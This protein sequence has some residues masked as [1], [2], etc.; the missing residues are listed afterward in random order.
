M[1]VELKKRHVVYM[2]I[3]T[4]VVVVA[5]TVSASHNG[6]EPLFTDLDQFVLFAEQ[7]V[8]LEEDV[9]I[10]S[11]DTGSN[12]EINIKK[13][14]I[15]SGN[16]FANTVDLEKRSVINGNASF[17][18]LKIKKDAEILGEQIT[19]VSLPIAILPTIPS[20]T[21]G[22]QNFTFTGDGNTLPQG[23]FNNVTLKKDATLTLSGGMYNVS[24]LILNN[25]STLIF[26]TTTTINIIKE[27]IGHDDVSILPDANIIFDDITINYDGR[28]NNNNTKEVGIKPVIFGKNS[29]LNFKLLAP[30][31]KVLLGQQTTLRGQ[32]VAKEIRVGKES[33]LSREELFEKESDLTKVVED[34]QG[35]LFVGNELV[36]E[37]VDTTTFSDAQA[38]AELVNGTIT[39]FDPNPPAYKIE[40]PTDTV[41]G[42][43]DAFQTIIASNNPLIIEV[44]PNVIAVYPL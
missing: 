15:I 19:P 13:D 20:F 39:G 27:L 4:F 40:L 3:F 25:N 1:T 6:S 43:V 38:V 26:S 8:N 21:T 36:V 31:A 44:F 5:L 33:V 35:V 30:T 28:A 2:A 22:T 34:E 10:S 17:N 23:N 32:I 14:S 24:R 16:L 12:E 9:Q 37:F 41:D 29:F 11:G 18:E 7:N 42:M